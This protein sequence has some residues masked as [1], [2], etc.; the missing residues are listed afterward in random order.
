MEGGEALNPFRPVGPQD[1]VNKSGFFLL[2]L[3]VLLGFTQVGVDANVVL[4][5]V[6]AQIQNLKGPVALALCCAN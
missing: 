4:A 5:L 6:L 2:K 3:L 1:Q